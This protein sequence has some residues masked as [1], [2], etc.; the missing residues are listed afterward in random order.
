MQLQLLTLAAAAATLLSGVAVAHPG[1]H[2][3]PSHAEI[4][5]RSNLAKRCSVQA[6]QFA[7]VRKKRAA[8]RRSLVSRSLPPVRRGTNVTIHTEGPH[9]STIQNDTCVLTPEVTRG[10]YTW[11]QSQMLRQDMSEDQAGV[12][13]YLDIG[14]LNVNTCEVMPDVLVD[15]WHCNATGFYSSF[16]H[17]NP[18]TPFLELIDQLNVTLGPDMDIHTDDTTF[19]RGIWPTDANGIMEMK[20]VFPG[21]YVDRTIHI[22]ALVHTDWTVRSN[23]T[24]VASNIVSSGQLFFDEDLSRQIMALEPYIGHTEINRTTNDIDTI[25][26]DE[27]AGSWNPNMVVE[28]LDG[29][30]VT[31]GMLAYI[32]IGIEA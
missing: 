4:A 8:E 20:T 15:L 12:P 30:D 27:F 6:G 2:D 26:A 5:R 28:P 14:V 18:N 31:K 25:F 29:E 19:L 9:Y 11:P 13:L 1:H 23:G 32:T 7:E 24:V 3:A 10:P 21:F 22:H 16:I 17:H